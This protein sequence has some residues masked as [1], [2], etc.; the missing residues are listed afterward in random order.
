MKVMWT[1]A[2]LGLPHTRIDAG[3][4]FGGLD[5]PDYKRMNP[6]MKVPT[7]QDGKL[8]LWESNAI[9]RYIADTYGKGRLSPAAPIERA[10][11]DQWIDWAAT[12]FTPDVMG[13][14]FVP[15]AY[16]LP[17]A[18]D[19]KAVE[20]AAARAGD[21]LSVLDAQLEGRPFILGDALTIA[22]IVVG[23]ALHRYYT[24]PIA[25]PSRP[26]VEA[27]YIRLTERPT[28]REHVMHDWQELKVPGA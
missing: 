10:H 25:R 4:R 22:D 3:G 23:G 24:L 11:A 14:V 26:N 27:Y 15:L 5:T 7:L 1:I 16:T 17:A 28:Y 12:G 18:R 6:N 19:M 21:K 9:V 20:A 13:G 8:T 2:E